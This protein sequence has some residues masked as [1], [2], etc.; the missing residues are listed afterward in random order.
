MIGEANPLI[1][2]FYIDRATISNSEF[3][4]VFTESI[5][6]YI[7]MKGA[8][9]MA[10]FL[11]TDTE[12]RVEC[13]NPTLLEKTDMD[14][15]N[16]LITDIATQ[17][18]MVKTEDIKNYDFLNGI[19]CSDNVRTWDYYNWKSYDKPNFYLQ[20][21]WNQTLVTMFNYIS[22]KIHHKSCRSGADNIRLHSCFK[23]LLDS[24]NYYNGDNISD[25]YL[26]T[27]DDS[28]PTD[29]IFIYSSQIFKLGLIPK[30]EYGERK[31]IEGGFETEIKDLNFIP[32]NEL[33]VEEVEEHKN[34][35]WGYI[36]IENYEESDRV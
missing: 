31:E 16:K 36:K 3:M 29:K 27:Y 18:S 20:E 9:I 34:N 6:K 7:E 26:V 13:I 30:V 19:C 24:L 33:S 21:D 14:K 22:A 10:F 11:P 4:G 28:L 17:F 35:L 15:V 25:R 1:L 12:E 5:N 23:G 2:V 8:N 32:V